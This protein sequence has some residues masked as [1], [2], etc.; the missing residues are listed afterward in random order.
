MEYNVSFIN[1]IL[2]EGIEDSYQIFCDMDG[3]LCDFKKGYKELTGIEIKGHIIIQ[4]WSDVD[5]HPSFWSDLDWMPDAKQLWGYIAKYQPNILSSPSASSTAPAQK[6]KWLRRLPN[7]KQVFFA[8][9]DDKQKWAGPKN[10]LIDDM[11]ETVDQ[12]INAGGIGVWH[13]NAAN[14]IKQLKQLGL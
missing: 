5:A 9:K 2:R 7:K 12:W 4:D 10:I 8:Q 11:K 1:K 14:T 6:I 13:T 3:V